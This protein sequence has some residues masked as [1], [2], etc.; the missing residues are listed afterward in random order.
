[1][2][3]YAEECVLF[4]DKYVNNLL[5]IKHCN[6]TVLLLIM[7]QHVMEITTLSLIII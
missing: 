5:F 3:T 7:S 1:M 4:C 2:D 6:V